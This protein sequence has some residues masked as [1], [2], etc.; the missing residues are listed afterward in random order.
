M[1]DD[2][3]TTPAAPIDDLAT[4]RTR[5][6][7]AKE[8]DPG[9]AAV[10]GFVL[11]MFFA[12]PLG[13][14]WGTDA[15][16]FS[17]ALAGLGWLLVLTIGLFIVSGVVG[18]E[19]TA[20]GALRTM[21]VGG[22]LA[23][24]GWFLYYGENGWVLP[25]LLAASGPIGG[26]IALRGNLRERAEAAADPP[27]GLSAETVAAIGALPAELVDAVREILD[28]A[29]TDVQAL[30]RLIDNGML[31]ASGQSTVA[32]RGDVD[33]AI[34]TLA[35]RALVADTMVRREDRSDAGPV[36]DGM[37]RIADELHKLT[38]A[39]LVAAASAEGT[40]AS[41]GE[42]IENLRLTTAGQNEIR[43]A[44]GEG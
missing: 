17:A 14:W 34:R 22:V 40:A 19:K 37:R 25:A 38:D 4:L 9:S 36:L 23:G 12:L 13:L 16:L 8:H 44:V 39:A 11:T 1:S 27:L 6:A 42:H 32:L 43:E 29:V 35:R 18:D 28:R 21:L 30:E 2:D 5:L 20:R 41:L 24:L 33:R 7:E 10:G 31:E 15:G 26:L 3:E